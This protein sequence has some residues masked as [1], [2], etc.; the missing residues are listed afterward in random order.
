MLRLPARASHTR[1]ASDW[2][3]LPKG[4]RAHEARPRQELFKRG[5]RMVLLVCRVEVGD[6]A[7]R[8]GT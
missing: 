7:P 3:R 2:Q 6:T 5:G 1:L 4:S 8:R